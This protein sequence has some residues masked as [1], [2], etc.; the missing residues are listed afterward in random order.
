MIRNATIIAV[1]PS[2]FSREM[3]GKNGIVGRIIFGL[4]FLSLAG[5]FATDSVH[6]LTRPDLHR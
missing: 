6:S 3:V 1:S 4:D 2:Q 5:H